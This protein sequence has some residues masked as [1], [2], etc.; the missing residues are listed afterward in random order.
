MAVNNT[1]NN[2]AE[3]RQGVM[4]GSFM[5][6]TPNRGGVVEPQPDD[7]ST[8]PNYGQADQHQVYPFAGNG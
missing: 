5:S 3:L 6:S 2:E 4:D 1:R 8:W 7:R